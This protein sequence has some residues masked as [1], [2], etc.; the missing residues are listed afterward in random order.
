MHAFVAANLLRVAGLDGFDA[1]TEAQPP[2]G[3]F[4]QIK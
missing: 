3:E 1:N 2:D 4:A